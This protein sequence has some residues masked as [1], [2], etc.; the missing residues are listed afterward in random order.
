MPDVIVGVDAGGTSTIAAV[1]SGG[2]IRTHE[3]PAANASS[4]GTESAAQIIADTIVGVLD[5][6]LP[7]VIFV[8]AAG[9]SRA[10]VARAIEETLKSRFARARVSVRDDAYIALRSGVPYGDGAVLIAGTGSIAFAERAG[11]SFRSGGYG[12]LLGDEG[13]GF[14]IGGASLKT[15]MRVYDGRTPRDA[16]VDAIE[17]ELGVSR[18]SDVLDAIYGEAHPVTRIAALAT[19]ALQAADAGERSAIKIVQTAALDLADLLKAAIRKADLG[20]SSAPIV[21]A[22]GLLRRNS[23]LTYLLE[24]RLQN[25]FPHMEIRKNHGEPYSGALAA[26]E[27]LAHA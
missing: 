10:V 14:S 7:D 3:G 1:S 24:T 21:F 4:R 18:A 23:V 20:G 12:Y 5:G 15:L 6:A 8:G 22:G 9:A 2:V 27:T 17:S 13:S 11:E 26:A 19:L 25:D 16:F